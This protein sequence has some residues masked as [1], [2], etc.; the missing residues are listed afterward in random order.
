MTGPIDRLLIADYSGEGLGGWTVGTLARGLIGRRGRRALMPI[1]P[2]SRAGA[3]TREDIEV[4]LPDR[5]VSSESRRQA[6]EWCHAVSL[7]LLE[8]DR[9]L[10]PDSRLGGLGS[11][12]RVGLELYL[13]Q[14]AA[15]ASAVVALH[16]ERRVQE[17]VILSPDRSLAAALSSLVP[18]PVR[19]RVMGRPSW[20]PNVLRRL[21]LRPD[22]QD[23]VL[24]G[25]RL[26]EE[27]AAMLPSPRAM[28][29]AESRPILQM[30]AAIEPHLDRLGVVPRL[31]VEFGT[32]P[33]LARLEREPWGARLILTR[34]DQVPPRD[35]YRF[36]PEL[37]G[38]LA[39]ATDLERAPDLA[40]LGG[41]VP[42]AFWLESMHFG[43]FAAIADHADRAR[44]LVERVQP[45]L[46]LVGNDRW[47]L[48]QSY[49]LAGRA[50]GRKSLWIQDGVP[51]ESP[52]YFWMTADHLAATSDGLPETLEHHGLNRSRITVTGQPRYDVLVALSRGSSREET[53]R[54]LG[55]Q[56]GAA[57]A[58]VATQPL[59]SPAYAREV[60]ASLLRVPALR[61]MLRPHPSQDHAALSAVA[62][63]FPAERVSFHDQGSVFDLLVACDLVVTQFSTVAIE[64]AIVGRPVITANFSGLPDPVPYARLGLSTAARD[65]AQVAELAR[66]MIEQGGRGFEATAEGLRLLVGPADGHA[67]ERVAE[68]ALRMTAPAA[69]SRA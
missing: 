18:G 43:K 49:V 51:V 45:D 39:R 40:W 46:L 8:S 54:R 2:Q 37:P 31:R 13:D 14:Y 42:L 62:A 67:G 65:L 26:F 68:L 55:L 47:W 61:I 20:L 21:R 36:L 52:V 63:G 15:V 16:R 10:F 35:P 56:P 12:A 60:I 19:R 22:A 6:H 23:L 3:M 5:L 64:A 41:P 25:T 17:T 66:R 33:A 7:R 32:D 9:G 50:L 38:A 28:L 59:Q 11:L 57:Y 4:I 34:P 27:A 44:R 30:F 69:A 1:D 24:G 58:M 53:R 29:I 48:G